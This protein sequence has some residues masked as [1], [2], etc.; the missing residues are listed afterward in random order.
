MIT[1]SVRVN[2]TELADG[3]LETVVL[4]LITTV[5]NPDKYIIEFMGIAT[6]VDRENLYKAVD[7]MKK[8]TTLTET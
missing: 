1:K 4:S 8:L 3:G 5:A 2:V 6:M 7:E